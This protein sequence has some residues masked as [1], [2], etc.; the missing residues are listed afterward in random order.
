MD[1][2]QI[3]FNINDILTMTGSN[4]PSYS[5]PDIF[6]KISDLIG[7]RQLETLTTPALDNL[8]SK[9]IDLFY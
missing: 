6:K 5:Y 3:I 7:G 9:I 1:R 8:Y 2:E 4:N